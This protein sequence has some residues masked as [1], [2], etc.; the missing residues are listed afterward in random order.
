MRLVIPY[1]IVLGVGTA[2]YLIDMAEFANES[3]RQWVLIPVVV[4]K[5]AYF[6]WALLAYLR[7]HMGEELRFDV[8]ARFTVMNVLLMV[9]SFAIDYYCLFQ[10]N[11]ES[12]RGA[13]S[14]DNMGEGLFSFMYFSISTFTT[15][16]FGDISPVGSVA[17]FFV[18]C[19]LG[20]SW[21]VTILVIGNAAHLHQS[22]MKKGENNP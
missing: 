20:L 18:T 11:P 3:V 22:L 12:F 10:I 21:L 14:T 9:F 17:R 8:F 7:D 5:S 16:G 1:L 4:F 2:I 6:L 13:I 15:A 19:Q